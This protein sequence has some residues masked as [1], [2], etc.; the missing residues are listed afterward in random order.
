MASWLTRP[1]SRLC[2]HHHPSL[3]RQWQLQLQPVACPGLS[4]PP[5][6]RAWQTPAHNEQSAVSAVFTTSAAAVITTAPTCC[7]KSNPLA[8]YFS[9]TALEQAL[10]R[11]NALVLINSV[12][13]WLM[14]PRSCGS[15]NAGGSVGVL[16]QELCRA[17]L[18]EATPDE[19][20][21]Q[22][23]TQWTV[24]M[25]LA[26]DRQPQ[27]LPVLINAKGQHT[28]CSSPAQL[29]HPPLGDASQPAA[30]PRPAPTPLV[31]TRDE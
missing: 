6:S 9:T 14:N 5:E 24:T 22:V 27:R 31:P 10:Q 8:T 23:A 1:K 26:V 3:S 20:P 7:K 25:I 2:H 18:R 16:L 15:I 12:R 28:H 19:A 13:K 17:A 21:G 30:V 4:T 29:G 11:S